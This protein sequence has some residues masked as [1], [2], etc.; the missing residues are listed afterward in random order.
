MDSD[1]NS[2]ISNSSE[3]SLLDDE[4][5]DLSDNDD[6]IQEDKEE[7]EYETFE[8]NEIVVNDELYD[9][10]IEETLQPITI[11][12]IPDNEEII[13]EEGIINVFNEEDT[14]EYIYNL[15]DDYKSTNK[16][17]LQYKKVIDKE[18]KESNAFFYSKNLAIYTN[19]IFKENTITQKQLNN[20]NSLPIKQGNLDRNLLFFPFT[21][22]GNYDKSFN[23][24]EKTLLIVNDEFKMNIDETFNNITIPYQHT[25]YRYRTNEKEKLINKINSIKEELFDEI[26]KLREYEYF[27]DINEESLKLEKSF[28]ELESDDIEYILNNFKDEKE[29]KIKYNNIKPIKKEIHELNNFF[30]NI[31]YNELVLS[32]LINPNDN[33]V[34]NNINDEIKEL[35]KNEIQEVL[36]YKNLE[37]ILNDIKTNVK[38]EDIQKNIINFL[39]YINQKNSILFLNE[40][41]KNNSDIIQKKI[42]IKTNNFNKLILKDYQDNLFPFYIHSEEI[43]EVIDSDN[44]TL[45]SNENKKDDFDEDNDQDMIIINNEEEDDIENEYEEN[46]GFDEEINKN[47]LEEKYEELIELYNKKDEKFTKEFKKIIPI[48]NEFKILSLMDIDVKEILSNIFELKIDNSKLLYYIVIEIYIIIQNTIFDDQLIFFRND[49]ITLWDTK[50]PIID[51]NNKIN[52]DDKKGVLQYIICIFEL[53]QNIPSDLIKQC[54]KILNTVYNERLNEIIEKYKINS[55]NLKKENLY[56]KAVQGLKDKNNLKNYVKALLYMPNSTKQAQINKYILGCCKQKISIDFNA[57]SDLEKDKNEPINKR[58]LGLIKDYM[59]TH[60]INDIN[61]NW[62]TYIL[63]LEESSKESEESSKE[64]EEFSKESEES[65]KESEESL[66]ESEESSEEL[67]EEEY[68]LIKILKDN[69][70]VLEKYNIT[71]EMIE[72]FV[73]KRNIFDEYINELKNNIEKYVTN[74]SNKFDESII[75]IIPEIKKEY[76]INDQLKELFNLYNIIGNYCVKSK[77]ETI[78]IKITEKVIGLL[79]LNL[80]DID[81]ELIYNKIIERNN[82]LYMPTLEKHQEFIAKIREEHKE[83]KLKKLEQYDRNEQELLKDLAKMGFAY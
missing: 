74:R 24:Y 68:N 82:Y 44:D 60:K 45:F 41:L 14:K 1:Q 4:L 76:L 46:I 7:V 73:N 29:Y 12:Y 5:L 47:V 13:K 57:F 62:N 63:E 11:K 61:K 38:M 25:K 30:N 8:N 71:K 78:K 15:F 51:E 52:K 42:E 59:D 6:E 33:D 58:K 28:Y 18:K 31:E 53:I 67:E 55:D 35:N 20:I 23:P 66:K 2:I 36:K 77:E 65:S 27:D 10:N 79:C 37:E 81:K 50:P 9:I 43:K 64:S 40:L 70:D 22:D 54:A 75:Y 26:P 83:E 34:K 17:Y 16:L 21:F 49:C 39:K 72:K 19:L 3:H 80:Q 69:I 56:I 32:D 48:I